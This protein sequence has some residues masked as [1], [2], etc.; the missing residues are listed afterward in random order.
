MRVLIHHHATA[1][2]RGGKLFLQSFICRWINEL[3]KNVEHVGYIAHSV[4]ELKV[5]HDTELLDTIRFHDLGYVVGENRFKRNKKIK[6]T[7][8]SLDN[9]YDVL[10]VRGITPRQAIIWRNSKIRNKYFLLVGSLIDGKPKLKFK[11]LFNYLMFHLRLQQFKSISQSGTVLVNSPKLSTELENNF[12]IQT[13]YVPTSSIYKDEI[14][15]EKKASP[16]LRKFIFCGRIVEDKGVVELLMALSSLKKQGKTFELLLVGSEG[17]DILKNKQYLELKHQLSDE[18]RS[19]GFVPYGQELLKLY[20]ES[21]LFILPSYHEG[22]P[23][24]I[25][26]AM[27]QSVPVVTTNVGGISGEVTQED[28]EFICVRSSSDLLRAINK[29]EDAKVRESFIESGLNK[30]KNKTVENSIETMLDVINEVN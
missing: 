3:A 22:F 9:E 20:R 17:H 13:S 23:H 1:A 28:V 5:T 19:C 16:I 2:R 24:S 14:V 26:E 30:V 18:I 11:G 25:W 12:N 15:I 8:Q 29:L 21:D 27:S 10:V 4:E 7:I 6:R